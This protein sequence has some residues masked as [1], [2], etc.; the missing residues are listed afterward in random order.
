MTLFNLNQ[1]VEPIFTG[2]KDTT[3][4]W[5]I[6]TNADIAERTNAQGGTTSYAHPFDRIDPAYAAKGLPMDVAL[7]RINA[8]DVMS[9]YYQ[10]N[11][12]LWYH[13]LNCGFRIPGAA[14]T[15]CM[16]NR[17]RHGPPG[18][19]RVYVHLPDGLYYEKWVSGLKAGRSFVSN[20]P[21]IEFTLGGGAIGDTLTLDQPAKVRVQGR[22]DA[23]FP[24]QLLELIHNGKVVATG[25]LPG[26]G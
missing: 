10:E 6:P 3:N 22:A 2:F 5:D 24:L 8:I 23:Q 4:P 15:D 16:L 7:G 26:T 18:W 17:V 21:M 11:V 25:A 1:L 19:G 12:V 14:G 13:V 20:G 9:S